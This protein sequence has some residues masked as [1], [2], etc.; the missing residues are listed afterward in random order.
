MRVVIAPDSFKG[1]ITAAAAATALAAGWRAARPGDLVTCLPLADGGEGTLEVLAARVPGAR[2]R[3]ARVTGPGGAPVTC[4]WLHLPGGAAAVELARAS[5][6]PLLARPDPM[7]AQTSGLGELLAIALDEG[8][9]R[10]LVGLGG[11]AATNSGAR[12]RW[13]P[14]APGSSTP[15]AARCRPAAGRWPGWPRS[16]PPACGHRLPGRLPCRCHRTAAGAGRRGHGV[17]PAKGRHSRPGGPAGGGPGPAGGPARRSPRGA[18]GRGRG[19]HRLRAGGRL[20]CGHHSRRPPNLPLAGLDQAIAATDLVVTG[21]GQR[22]PDLTDREGD[23]PGAGRRGGRGRPGGGRGRAHSGGPPPPR[24]CRPHPDRPGGRERARTGRSGAL[25]A[26]GR[27]G[28]GTPAGGERT[29]PSSL[30]QR[31]GHRRLHRQR[32]PRSWRRRSAR[33]WV[34]RCGRSKSSGS[35]ATAWRS[36]A[37]Q[38][39]NAGNGMSSS[40]SR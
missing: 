22:R 2:W 16:T 35:P 30:G 34:S 15:L 14:S 37:L 11:S 13:P 23:G 20:G 32:P 17:R 1:S 26:Q 21:E 40:S 8:A 3:R 36:D 38:M 31:A 33:S 9:R 7:R 5:G 27:P 28:T 39:K 25:A 29:Q 24:G 6:L 19:R 18:R 12:G 4:D 10:L